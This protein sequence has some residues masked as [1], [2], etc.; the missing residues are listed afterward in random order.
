MD[1]GK[2]ILLGLDEI[3]SWYMGDVKKW[4]KRNDEKSPSAGMP[5]LQ[6][7]AVWKPQ[8]IEFLWDSLLRGFPI[9]SLLWCRR[10]EEQEDKQ[11]V[12]GSGTGRGKA[13]YHILDGQQRCNAIALGFFLPEAPKKQEGGTFQLPEQNDSGLRKDVLWLD[14]DLNREDE[15][16]PHLF[17]VVTTAHPWGFTDDEASSRLSQNHIYEFRDIYNAILDKPDGSPEYLPCASLPQRA[18]MPIPM[19]LLLRYIRNDEKPAVCWDEL[20]KNPWILFIDAWLKKKHK[21]PERET[22]SSFLEKAK[23]R[24]TIEKW[25]EP[26]VAFRI[27]VIEF[28]LPN[29]N[30]NPI[31]AVA[32][33]F[34]RIN[35]QGTSINQE[36]LRYSM[37]K[38]YYPQI[39]EAI[40]RIEKQPGLPAGEARL[41][42]LGMRAALTLDAKDNGQKKDS[43]QNK[44]IASVTDNQIRQWFLNGQSSDEASIIKRYFEGSQFEYAINWVENT[45]VY[46][47]SNPAGLPPYLRSSI[48]WRSPEVYLWWLLL[49]GWFRDQVIS[50]E[51]KKRILAL[52]TVIHWFGWKK[53][54]LVQSLVQPPDNQ[55]GDEFVLPPFQLSISFLLKEGVSPHKGVESLKEKFIG[56]LNAAWE[57]KEHF[58]KTKIWNVWDLFHQ[59]KVEMTPEDNAVATLLN[60]IYRERE[61]LVYAQRKALSKLDYDPSKRALWE[62]INRPWDYDH[63]LASSHFDGTGASKVNFVDGYYIGQ[64]MQRSIGNLMALPF[65]LN[66]SKGAKSLE[67]RKDAPGI[68][69]AFFLDGVYKGKMEPFYA[70]ESRFI[71]STENDGKDEKCKKFSQE[72]AERMMAIYGAWYNTLEVGSAMKLSDANG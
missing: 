17:R 39:E 66:R 65:S 60:T 44:K 53:E 72:A 47:D 50:E 11:L 5:S 68:Q 4:S 63:I 14:L 67:E 36:E 61:L 19:G 26:L 13:T 20:L 29:N 46:S 43:V 40:R 41:V 57:K 25:L 30:N 38:A 12:V 56:Y 21:D 8:Q 45:L 15:I 1:S 52:S 32:L 10:I 9:G 69:E 34:K 37:I 48:A 18:M 55:R 70:P 62:S 23:N 22:L 54:Y 7:N 16:R 6:R 49:A 51:E 31:D 71:Y 64:F 59:V 24:E 28:S 2:N 3:A 42:T 58:K 33:L 27:P 35:N